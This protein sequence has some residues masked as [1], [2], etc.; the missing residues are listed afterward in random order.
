MSWL[1]VVDVT[2]IA[3]SLITT[4]QA[5]IATILKADLRVIILLKKITIKVYLNDN[6][7]VQK[8]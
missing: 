5:T 4:T 7:Q 2:A 1:T 8:H 6:V 3:F